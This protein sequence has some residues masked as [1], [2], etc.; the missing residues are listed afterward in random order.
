MELNFTASQQHVFL[1]PAVLANQDTAPGD[2]VAVSRGLRPTIVILE[3]ELL[4]GDALL[5]IPAYRAL[6]HAFPEHRIVALASGG[7]AFAT[8]LAPF[9]RLFVDDVLTNQPFNE[10]YKRQREVVRS[11]G[12]IDKVLYFRA[13]LRSLTTF[14]NLYPLANGLVGNSS[15]YILRKG[16][17]FG[18]D[19]RRRSN[20]ERFHQMAELSAGHPMPFDPTLPELPAAEAHA[21]AMLPG[22]QRYFG[23]TTTP[24]KVVKTWPREGLVAV[25]NSIRSRGLQPV[26][27]LGPQETEQRGWF[28]QNIPEAKIVGLEEA[29]GDAAYLLRLFHA[30]AGRLVGCVANESGLG[31]LLSTRDTALLTLAGPTNPFRWKPVTRY[32]WALRAQQFGKIDMSAIPPEAV[33]KSVMAII[34]YAP[35]QR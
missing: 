27:M 6:R 29:N 2:N 20:A 16:A 31:H 9:S 21:A 23:I 12:P 24:L 7:S 28:V 18:I 11:F 26:I 19:V 4:L 15:G 13:N 17:G 35:K 10:S 30:V 3:K 32:W 1:S 8:T 22:T 34:D 25:A 5:R 14:I 33:I